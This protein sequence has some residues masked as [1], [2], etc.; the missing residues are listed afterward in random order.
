MRR[1]SL[2]V[3]M[4]V[5]IVALCWSSALARTAFRA[6]ATS[7][8]VSGSRILKNGAEFVIHGINVNGPGWQ[9]KRKTVPDLDFIAGVWK[10]NLVR[11]NCGISPKPGAAESN[12]L[13]EI[14]RAF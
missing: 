3:L 1:R 10:F 13:D 11:V 4:S 2:D 9:W 8:S 7:F 6:P 14:V 12:D 5:L